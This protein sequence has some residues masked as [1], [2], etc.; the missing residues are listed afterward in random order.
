VARDRLGRLAGA[1][2]EEVD[3]RWPPSLQIR[4][5]DLPRGEIGETFAAVERSAPWPLSSDLD[6]RHR[7][8]TVAVVCHGGNVRAALLASKVTTTE[9]P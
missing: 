8:K 7:G 3:Q 9:R 2:P 4:E 5:L 1:D 6:T